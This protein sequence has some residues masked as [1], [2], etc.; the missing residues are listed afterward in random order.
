MI[1]LRGKVI[2]II[3][4]HPTVVIYT[5]SHSDSTN[6]LGRLDKGCELIESIYC[7]A[8]QMAKKFKN[9]FKG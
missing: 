7:H 8:A 1:G 6:I 2:K 3:R 4:I 9:F 5:G